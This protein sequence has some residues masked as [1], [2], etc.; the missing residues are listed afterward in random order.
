M[1]RRVGWRMTMVLGMG[2]GF[3]VVGQGAAAPIL[4]AYT[5]GFG[6]GAVGVAW[7]V[8]AY[9]V[10]RLLVTVPTGALAHRTNPRVMLSGGCL[11]TA[12]GVIGTGLS[13][14]FPLLFACRT[15]G[16]VGSGVFMTSAILTIVANAPLQHRA[17]LIGYN[18][19]ALLGTVSVAPAVGGIL[20][21]TVGLRGS[22]IAVGSLSAIG[23]ALVWTMLPRALR[24]AQEAADEHEGAEASPPPIPQK[25]R[26][27]TPPRVTGV[28]W[29][30]FLLASAVNF[31]IF[32]TRA[33]ARQTIMPLIAAE[34][35]GMTVGALGALFTM[36]SV[37]SLIVLPLASVA[38]DRFGRVAT[39]APA[40]PIAAIGLFVWASADSV[41]A[42]WVGGAALSLGTS[43]SGPAPAALA[44]DVTPTQR[45][46][47]M[48]SAF[49]TA[50]DSGSMIGPI[51][52]GWI[53]TA[54][55][56]GGSLVAHGIAL[57]AL[58]VAVAIVGVKVFGN[59]L[60]KR[61]SP[62]PPSPS[63]AAKQRCQTQGPGS[64]AAGAEGGR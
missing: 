48:L 55:S 29:P 5:L 4:P 17:R 54:S 8:S 42:L 40:L 58:G 24:E 46:G 1:A 35:F 6:V 12:F 2:T 11:I 21:E 27:S 3:V 50:G 36:M 31:M 13:P 51:I 57:A 33:G 16:G 52:L 39:I 23:A 59:V 62:N 20:G 34:R 38:G 49:R 64:G 26:S 25:R 9:S 37:I 56:F 32:A 30:A 7:A 44:A 45:H 63:T 43:L 41:T 28:I 47:V 10:G 53:A 22:F 18:Q 14:N 19:T 60:P 15:L 61:R